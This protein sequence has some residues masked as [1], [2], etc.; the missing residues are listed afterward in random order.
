MDANTRCVEVLPG[1]WD[2]FILI[3]VKRASYNMKLKVL[4]DISKQ[5]I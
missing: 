5:K 1:I 3:R 2:L 4:K